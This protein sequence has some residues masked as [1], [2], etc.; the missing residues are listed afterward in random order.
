MK[1]GTTHEHTDRSIEAHMGS[2]RSFGL[3]FAGF[4]GII[5]LLP[6]ASGGAARYWAIAVAAVFLAVAML[7]PAWLNP[8]NRLWFLFGQ[9][10]HRIMSPVVL[11]VMFFAM[12]T[13]IAM[14][15]R[16]LGRDPLKLRLDRAATSYWI[17]RVP[18]GPASDSFKNQF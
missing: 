10:L 9:A 3:V 15:T 17:V 4:F 14:I 1:A 13:P 12:F 18:P 6:L 7:V 8:L 5:C 2:D 11:G 16:A